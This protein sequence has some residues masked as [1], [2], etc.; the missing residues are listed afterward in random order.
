MSPSRDA[1]VSVFIADDYYTLCLKVGEI[2]KLQEKLKESPNL[3]FHRLLKGWWMLEDITETIRLGL[4]GGGM[5]GLEAYNFV[6]LHVRE[7]Y[8]EEMALVARVVLQAAIVGDPGDNA[9]AGEPE[10]PETEPTPSP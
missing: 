4:I 3:V 9:D 1:S 10:A 6:K 7:G 8:L 5:D 2:I